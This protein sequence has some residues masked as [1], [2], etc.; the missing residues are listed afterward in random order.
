MRP[1]GRRLGLCA[2][3]SR[4]RGATSWQRLTKPGRKR[5]AGTLG[6]LMPKTIYKKVPMRFSLAVIPEDRE[7]LLFEAQEPDDAATA[8]DGELSSP[9]AQVP[10]DAATDQDLA[11]Q[12]PSDQSIRVAE[13]DITKELLAQINREWMLREDEDALSPKRGE[14]LGGEEVGA[15]ST[16]PTVA[17]CDAGFTKEEEEAPLCRLRGTPFCNK[18][19]QQLQELTRGNAGAVVGS[20]EDKERLRLAA[21]IAPQMV[22]ARGRRKATFSEDVEALKED[23]EALKDSAVEACSGVPSAGSLIWAA[24]ADRFLPLAVSASLAF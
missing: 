9:E 3:R 10:H 8:Q 7:L 21:A 2:K 12:V 4:P 5:G 18:D 20:S 15:S 23:V 14:P 22:Q 11:H 6:L 17:R 24:A 13:G 16:Q 1:V 19:M